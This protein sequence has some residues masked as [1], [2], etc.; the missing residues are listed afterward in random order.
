MEVILL[1]PVGLLEQIITCV[2]L[3]SSILVI[4]CNVLSNVITVAQI[5]RLSVNHILELLK[6]T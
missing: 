2:L 4:L 1:S 5:P 3:L 6:L